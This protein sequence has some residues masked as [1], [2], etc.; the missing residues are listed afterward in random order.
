MS[1]AVP[2]ISEAVLETIAASTGVGEYVLIQDTRVLS[3][4]AYT[5]A[6][7]CRFPTCA[8]PDFSGVAAAWVMPSRLLIAQ[9]RE[10]RSSPLDLFWTPSDDRLLDT[11]I[12][13][14][15]GC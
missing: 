10:I 3:I 5:V 7:T 4:V 12:A 15:M 9:V 11:V 14:E 8:P 2:E 13:S 1:E 6:P